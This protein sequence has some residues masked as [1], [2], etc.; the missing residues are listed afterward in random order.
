MAAGQN[1]QPGPRPAKPVPIPGDLAT[2]FQHVRDEFAT[3]GQDLEGSAKEIVNKIL[4]AL[5]NPKELLTTSLPDLI[6]K[7]GGLVTGLT[8]LAKAIVDLVFELLDLLF[9]MW[10]AA[11]ITPMT[12]LPLIGPLLAKVDSSLS[13]LNVGE[14]GALAAAFPFV[15]AWKIK[16]GGSAV[17]PFTTQAAASRALAGHQDPLPVMT[18][19]PTGDAWNIMAGITTIV[20]GVNDAFAATFAIPTSEGTPDSAPVFCA[21]FDIVW[22]ALL[23]VCAYPTPTTAASSTSPLMFTTTHQR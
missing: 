13:Q 14:F 3:A 2:R 21:V 9:S 11:L 10:R 23:I 15:I 8:E 7:L 17:V 22:P 1:P 6:R 16:Y 19:A 5:K 12:E 20:L 4:T 18:A